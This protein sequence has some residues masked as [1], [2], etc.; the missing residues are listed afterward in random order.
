[1]LL[2]M[3][4]PKGAKKGEMTFLATLAIEDSKGDGSDVL[5]EVAQVLE[6]F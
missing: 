5:V 3:Q 6:L 4:V 2:A 1:M